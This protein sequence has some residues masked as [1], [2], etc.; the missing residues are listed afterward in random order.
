MHRNVI[1][2]GLLLLTTAACSD[3][4]E[5]VTTG[6]TT[7]A[8]VTLPPGATDPVT[9][10]SLAPQTTFMADCGRMPSP[11]DLS[12]AVGVAIDVGLVTGPASCEYV[13][14]N[15]QSL[16]IT[17][18]IYSTPEEVAAF[19]DLVASTGTPTPLNDP[20]IPDA[21]I[22]PD[23]TVFVTANSAIYVVRT[24]VT[25]GELAAEVAPAAAVL[26]RWLAL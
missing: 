21:Q 10:E 7:V 16:T 3:D 8:P 25:G 18:S 11:A 2:A 24:R 6:P 9:G 4:S 26:A 13:G 19:N 1:L 17:L 23:Y 15:D 12:A 22:S 5:S 14:L 20:A